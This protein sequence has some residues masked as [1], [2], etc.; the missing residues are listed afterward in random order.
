MNNFTLCSME[1]VFL[2]ALHIFLIS[3]IILFLFFPRWSYDILIS[4]NVSDAF[5]LIWNKPPELLVYSFLDMYCLLKFNNL[6]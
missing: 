1:T 6:I 5:S 2:T 3:S 4:V